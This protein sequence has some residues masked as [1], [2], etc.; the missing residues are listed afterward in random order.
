MH[1]PQGF[2]NSPALFGEA[3]ARDLTGLPREATCCT[4]LQYG[5]DVLLAAIPE[6]EGTRVLLQLLS[7]SGYRVS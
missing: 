3:L 5:D 6:R 4:L 2:K 1:L 7:D